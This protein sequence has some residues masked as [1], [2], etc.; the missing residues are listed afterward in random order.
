MTVIAKHLRCDA[1]KMC[2]QCS[3]Y[4]WSPEKKREHNMLM[5]Y[6]YC[7]FCK[8]DILCERGVGMRFT[9]DNQGQIQKIFVCTKCGGKLVER[10]WPSG[11][12]L[13]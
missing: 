4:L 3:D 10:V 6:Y 8:I 7:P 5:V 2:I 1:Q 12:E 13:K 11:E 9:Q